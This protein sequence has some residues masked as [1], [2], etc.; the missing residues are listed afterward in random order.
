MSRRSISLFQQ[1]TGSRQAGTQYR[2]LFVDGLYQDGTSPHMETNKASTPRARISDE[3]LKIGGSYRLCTSRLSGDCMSRSLVTTLAKAKLTFVRT[4]IA[5]IH[6]DDPD[7]KTPSAEELTQTT[8][9]AGPSRKPFT[10]HNHLLS[11]K[12]PYFKIL[13]S[14]K[15]PPTKDQLTFETIDEFAAAIFVRWLYGGELH[16]PSDFHSM[17]HYL[18]LY[19]L[20]FK[21]DV[22]DL[23]NSGR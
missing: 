22:E 18:S 16:G 15:V 1:G 7:A 20:G 23:C 14:S 12:V 3:D 19:V 13:L 17:H 8:F 5:S 9:F 21:W 2:C 4:L 11:K 10:A 6:A